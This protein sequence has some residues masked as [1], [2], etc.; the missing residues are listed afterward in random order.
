MSF[1]TNLRM[2]IEKAKISDERKA[3]VKRMLHERPGK[4]KEAL[5]EFMA[6]KEVDYMEA[7]VVEDKKGLEEYKKIDR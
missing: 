1:R 5:K 7:Q 6:E 4:F 2:A 3:K